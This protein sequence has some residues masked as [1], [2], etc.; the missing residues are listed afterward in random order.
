MKIEPTDGLTK[1]VKNELTGGPAVT[2]SN[3][4]LL[5]DGDG[6]E[7]G[8]CNVAQVT[9]STEIRECANGKCEESMALVASMM[10]SMASM[11]ASMASMVASMASMA[12]MVVASMASMA[13]MVAS[14]V[15]ASVASMV[16]LWLGGFDGVEGWRRMVVTGFFDTE[17]TD[18]EVPLCPQ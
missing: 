14:M 13:S 18:V 9:P 7:C 5:V 6:S 10:E 2:W 11:V 12:S 4:K 8:G 15:V 17:G 1:L 3:S 16:A